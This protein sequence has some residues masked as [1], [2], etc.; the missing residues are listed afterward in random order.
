MFIVFSKPQFLVCCPLKHQNET[1]MCKGASRT[2]LF[3]LAT[4]QPRASLKVVS[5]FHM[6]FLRKSMKTVCQD[7]GY[8]AEI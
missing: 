5:S 2:A 1:N 6:E 8:L 7:F 3:M 4:Q